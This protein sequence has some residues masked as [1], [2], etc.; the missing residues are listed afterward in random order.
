MLLLA[1]PQPSDT[2]YERDD[3]K[4]TLKI[5]LESFTYSHIQDSV[6]AVLNQLKTENIEQLIVAFPQPE[7]G[8]E[9]TVDQEWL[10]KVLQVKT[11]S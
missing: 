4:I 5:F 9:T 7:S 3:L 11:A 10:Q 6:D 2:D 8:D 1:E